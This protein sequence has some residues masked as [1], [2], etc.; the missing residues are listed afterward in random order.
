MNEIIGTKH[1]PT[2][3]GDD[4][5]SRA[6]SKPPILIGEMTY[7]VLLAVAAALLT[8]L[9]ALPFTMPDRAFAEPPTAID[10]AGFGRPRASGPPPS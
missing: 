7:L 10:V 3:Q 5:R 1:T 2:E 9:L 8:G 4:H 6:P